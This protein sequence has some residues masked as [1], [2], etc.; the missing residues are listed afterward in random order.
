M[1]NILYLGTSIPSSE[2]VLLPSGSHGH[3]NKVIPDW[4]DPRPRNNAFSRFIVFLRRR[5]RECYCVLLRQHSKIQVHNLYNVLC[6]YPT[7]VLQAQRTAR[8]DRSELLASNVIVLVRRLIFGFNRSLH[9]DS[10][11]LENWT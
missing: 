9:S 6:V 11:Q 3:R 7:G 5:A 10:E 8:G 1:A 2:F 4:F